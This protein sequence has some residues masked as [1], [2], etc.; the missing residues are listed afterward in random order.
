MTTSPAGCVL[1][2][3]IYHGEPLLL[4]DDAPLLAHHGDPCGHVL[5][6]GVGGDGED[7][8]GVDGVDVD[9]GNVLLLGGGD[10]GVLDPV[11]GLA[12]QLDHFNSEIA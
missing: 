6:G 1:G 7:S 3:P 9:G 2:L 4:P 5:R 10:D 12:L 11:L 8:V